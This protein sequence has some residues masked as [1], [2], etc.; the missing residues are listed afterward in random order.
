VLKID[1]SFVQQICSDP[2]IR[3][4]VAAVIE[5][6]R[7]LKIEVVAEGLETKSQL[8][9]LLSMGCAVGQGYFFG[10]PLPVESILRNSPTGLAA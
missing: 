3:S 2:E 4:I 10:R 7:S 8:D 9:M 6:A 1:M 5:L